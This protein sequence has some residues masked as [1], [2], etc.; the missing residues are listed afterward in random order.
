MLNQ[1]SGEGRLDFFKPG[2][3]I[4][5]RRSLCILKQQAAE[6]GSGNRASK[7]PALAKDGLLGGGEKIGLFRRF[8]AFCNHIKVEG[9]GHGQNLR[10][11]GYNH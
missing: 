9:F 8:N 1:S 3:I 4:A 6:F 7:K 10:Q 2:H 5:T 11:N